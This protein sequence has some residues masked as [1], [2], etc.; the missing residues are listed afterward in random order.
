MRS[1]TALARCGPA[2]SALAATLLLLGS[3]CG[4]AAQECE[5]K[6]FYDSREDI[7]RRFRW[8]LGDI[9]EDAEAL[10]GAVSGAAVAIP[11]MEKQRGR[12][13]DS[14]ESLSAALGLKFDLEA[15]AQKAKY[16]VTYH[17]SV[18]TSFYHGPE[19]SSAAGSASSFAERVEEATAFVYPEIAAL[20]RSKLEAFVENPSMEPYRHLMANIARTRAH[21][22]SPQM[23]F[24]LA[25]ADRLLEAPNGIA[26][27][28]KIQ[29]IEWPKV[30]TEDGSGVQVIPGLQRVFTSSPDRG[31]RREGHQALIRTYDQFGHTL[32]AAL[33]SHMEGQ[34]W[35]TKA[36]GYNTTL[37]RRL[38]EVNVPMQVVRTMVE[39]VRNNTAAVHSYVALRKREL[40][41]EQLHT[42]DT[43]VPLGIQGRK[44]YCYEEAADLALQF[45]REVYGEEY[46]RV[47][48]TAVDNRWVDVFANSG[49]M[50]GA[51]VSWIYGVHPYMLLNWEGT[52]RDVSILVHELGHVVH[53]H[54]SNA[55]QPY[56]YSA[57]F[58]PAFLHEVAG[59]IN[60][61]LFQEWA[62]NRTEDPEEKI[63]LLNEGIQSLSRVL[64]RRILMHEFEETL[65]QTIEG[66]GFLSKPGMT[67]LFL[68]LHRQYYGPDLVLD[69]AYGMF[70]AN[71]PHFY[72]TYY[73]WVYSTSYAAGEAMASRIRRGDQGAAGDYIK[74]LKL[75][76]SV[77][78]LEALQTAGVDLLDPSVI[79]LAMMRYQNLTR[80]LATELG[81][82]EQP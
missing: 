26:N 4:V 13:G 49:K 38:D 31:V 18:N 30:A 6:L 39:S 37:E 82:G 51:Y 11:E 3:L 1:K 73:L 40:G 21:I 15:E 71:I 50:G 43:D 72:A 35:V 60:E 10:E 14:A 77:Y 70:F 8:S 7:P 61:N 54:L 47:A 53:V 74:M 79:G 80:R 48:E 24:L 46:A 57:E 36:R 20:P 69:D 2:P 19:F 63:L 55:N 68:D 58:V 16:Y 78:P 27:S 44:R 64:I 75:G 33:A 41:V 45:F 28:L 42:Y 65:Y 67:T 32:S 17:Q 29:D 12:L 9:Y 25:G 22:L 59:V 56:H 66:G 62:M 76:S 81:M 52:I 5:D 23:E 34:A